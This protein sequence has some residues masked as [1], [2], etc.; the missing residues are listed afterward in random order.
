MN[1]GLLVLLAILLGLA[2]FPALSVPRWRIRALAEKHKK[3]VVHDWL[4]HT[5]PTFFRVEQESATQTRDPSVEIL[6]RAQD[7]MRAGMDQRSAWDE[8]N[9]PTDPRGIPFALPL[10]YIVAG[11]DPTKPT[12][13]IPRQ[14]ERQAAGIVSACVLA[15]ELGVPLA[16]IFSTL[17]NALRESRAAE[18]ERTVAL[19]GP[20]A[21]AKLLQLLPALGIGLGTILGASPLAWFMGSLPGAVV[22]GGGVALVVLG[23][24]WTSRLIER[25]RSAG[26]PI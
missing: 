23:R 10:A 8:L 6:Q 26:I 7:L 12:D 22:G 24:T 21:S 16:A 18:D 25:A 14:A 9:I 3:S 5:F 4:M 11:V 17:S 19:S 15:H 1:V 20:I 13:A 2:L